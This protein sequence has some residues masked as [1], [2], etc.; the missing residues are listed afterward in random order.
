LAISAAVRAREHRWV[1]RDEYAAQ[2]AAEP[3]RVAA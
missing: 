3:Y 2:L 1:A